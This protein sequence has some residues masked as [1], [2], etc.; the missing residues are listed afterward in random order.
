MKE[1]LKKFENKVPEITF[2]WNDSET[3]AQGDHLRD[4]QSEEAREPYFDNGIVGKRNA[5]VPHFL[6]PHDTNSSS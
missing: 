5:S 6:V 4:T 3:E 1:L 2:E